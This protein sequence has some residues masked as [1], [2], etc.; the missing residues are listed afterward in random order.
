MIVGYDV[1]VP[2]SAYAQMLG[3]A[4]Q[5]TKVVKYDNY[6]YIKAFIDQ[7]GLTLTPPLH[8]G[9]K[10]NSYDRVIFPQH[11]VHQD[12]S[13]YVGLPAATNALTY[14]TLGY[15][16]SIYQPVFQSGWTART[17]HNK[18]GFWQDLPFSKLLG[19]R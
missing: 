3:V 9:W 15:K 5:R 8:L 16:A 4:Y 7:H 12:V 2:V 11:G 1:G 18:Q 13:F 6:P 10:S 19:G 14:Y 17:T